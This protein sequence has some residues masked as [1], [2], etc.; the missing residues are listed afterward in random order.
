MFMNVVREAPNLSNATTTNEYGNIQL[1]PN[2]WPLIQLIDFSADGN[3]DI[4][5]N[6][7]GADEVV[8]LVYTDGAEGLSFDKDVY[9]LKHEVGVT[10]TDWNLNIDP[11]DKTVGPL[12]HYQP[13]Q[14][15]SINYLM[16]M[17]QQTP[18]VLQVLTD[19]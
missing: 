12:V 11:T 19:V 2:M 1:G 8:N 16:R 7:A 3:I 13:T 15:Y 4:V 6:R 9:G 10:L 18:Q 17:V 5:Y 14:H